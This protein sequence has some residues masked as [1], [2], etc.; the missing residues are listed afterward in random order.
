MRIK[1]KIIFIYDAFCRLKDFAKNSF[2]KA[3]LAPSQMA[4]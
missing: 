4:D 3:F 2:I 1:K